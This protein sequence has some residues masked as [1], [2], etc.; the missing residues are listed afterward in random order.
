MV[1]GILIALAQ[2]VVLVKNKKRRREIW[3]Y[4]ERYLR[5]RN[6]MYAAVRSVCWETVSWRMEICARN[7][8]RSF[9]PGLKN[10]GAVPCKI[11]KDS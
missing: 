6:A 8:Q 10:A 3:D 9:R 1:E 11:L 5:K 7:V 2:T 4:L